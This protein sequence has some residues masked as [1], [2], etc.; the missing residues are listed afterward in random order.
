MDVKVDEDT[1]DQKGVCQ[2]SKVKPFIYAHDDHYYY[3]IGRKL[4]RGFD[5]GKAIKP[6]KR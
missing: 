1:L 4:A 2:I 5:S 3:R 6:K